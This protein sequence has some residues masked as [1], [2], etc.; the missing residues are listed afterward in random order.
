METKSIQQFFNSYSLKM[1]VVSV[2]AIVLLIPSF[3][4]QEIIQERIAL[5]DQVKN[6]LFGQWGGKQVISGPVL[7]VPYKILEPVGNN[8][9]YAEKSGVA[10]FLPETLNVEGEMV[11]ESRKRG[12]YK[13]VV[14]EGKLGMSGSFA[15]PDVSRLDMP[16]ANF[17]WDAAYF[18]MG[19]SDMRGIKNLPELILNGQRI[20]VESGVADND[21]FTSGITVKPDTMESNMPLSFE[22]D[23]VLNGS[24]DLSVEALGKISD[25]KISSV[26]PH[27]GFTGGFLPSS[28]E[29][30]AHGFNASWQVTHLN[31][32]FPQQWTDNK[33]KTD[34]ARLGV[35]LIIPVDHYQKSMRSVKY[36]ILFI[37][38]NFIVFIFIEISSKVRIHPFQYSLV[39]FALIIFYALLTSLGEQIGFNLSYLVS[40]VAVTALITWFSA[41][42][43]RNSTMALR[44]AALQAGL[45]I[46]LFAILQLNDYALL[47]GSV[48]LFIILAV[49]MKA[50]LKVKWYSDTE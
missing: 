22:I 6:E 30:T 9:G 16:N 27:P 39:A 19:I 12:I 42:L 8:L 38:L 31:R 33:F 11:P 13:V 48:G 4:I 21:L 50:S 2:L 25:V 46:F 15:Q 24:E 1:V 40:A 5:S 41:S 37:A 3:L 49:I 43:L 44:V 14:Y 29:V 26:W 34:G 10:H 17:N 32:N 36:A 47:T 20:T 18:T 7:N 35:E 45:Y 28:R 23:L